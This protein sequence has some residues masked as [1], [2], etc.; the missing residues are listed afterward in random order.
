M[1]LDPDRVLNIDWVEPVRARVPFECLQGEAC[2]E[3]ISRLERGDRR[4]RPHD[5]GHGGRSQM[6]NPL[7]KRGWFSQLRLS[8]LKVAGVDRR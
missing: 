5:L 3:N 2:A 8:I 1:T 6:N 7:G 4:G